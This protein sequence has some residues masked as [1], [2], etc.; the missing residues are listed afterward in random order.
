MGY[1]PIKRTL[2]LNSVYQMNCLEGM[3]LISDGSIDMILT[4]LPYGTTQN[5]WDVIIPFDQLWKEY[6]RIIKE[7][8]AIVL[9]ASQPFTSALIMSNS[10]LFRYEWIWKKNNATGHLNAKRMPM[11]EHESIVVFYKKQPT[12]NPQGIIP[13]NKIT[14]R[15]G[16][17]KNYNNSNTMNYQE[18]TNYPRTIQ[19]FSYDKEKYHPTQKPVALF[20]YLIKTYTNEGDV[21]LDNCMGSGTTAV[22]CENLKRN[23]IG[24]ET[25]KEYID[26]VNKRLQKLYHSL[27]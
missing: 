9:T 16:N 6:N 27:G 1:A 8:G 20:E 17:G 3:K 15:G 18:Y 5:K 7:N 26:I 12:Y 2:E 10:K 19:Q 22:A 21:V 14:R 24:F 4:D 25:E 13:Y 11:K 23:W